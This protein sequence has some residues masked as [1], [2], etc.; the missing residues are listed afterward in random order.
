M[1]NNVVAIVIG[2]ILILVVICSIVAV[3]VIKRKNNSK[4]KGGGIIVEGTTTKF[5]IEKCLLPLISNDILNNSVMKRFLDCYTTIIKKEIVAKNENDINKDFKVISRSIS[6]YNEFI[7]TN[8]TIISNKTEELRELYF[9][10]TGLDYLNNT[11]E[12]LKNFDTIIREPAMKKR[13]NDLI[14][15]FDKMFKDYEHKSE[16]LELAKS[17]SE[18]GNVN[19]EW[20]KFKD[21]LYEYYNQTFDKIQNTVTKN[22]TSTEIPESFRKD[23]FRIVGYGNMSDPIKSYMDDI[24]SMFVNHKKEI[25][26]SFDTNCFVCQSPTLGKRYDIPIEASESTLFKKGESLRDWY[27]NP[28]FREISIEIDIRGYSD[29]NYEHADV[30]A[31]SVNNAYIQSLILLYVYSGGNDKNKLFR[32][33]LATYLNM[34]FVNILANISEQKDYNK[35]VSNSFFIT[36]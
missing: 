10:M 7:A 27:N 14:K 1:V 5:K 13:A 18:N 32:V 17:I 4:E 30:I 15:D 11:R 31:A 36:H 20:D 23:Y 19:D 21:M 22:I 26:I 35:A 3:F 25:G 12:Y 29:R 6:L 33:L 9:K 28:F 8:K 2:V 34:I 24:K 16:I